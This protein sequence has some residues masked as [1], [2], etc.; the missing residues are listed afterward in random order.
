LR[1]GDDGLAIGE[2]A[3]QLAHA[4]RVERRIVAAVEAGDFMPALDK[5]A[6]Q[7]LAQET[8][9]A[10]D[11]DLHAWLRA[12]AHCASFSRPILAL[13][14]M[15]TGKPGWNAKASMRAVCGKRVPMARSSVSMRACSPRAT[16]A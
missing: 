2:V 13:W 14:R 5:A 9:A 7:R 4:Q 6:A 1:R 3:A 16:L 8:A 12:A 10:G 11:E 15:S